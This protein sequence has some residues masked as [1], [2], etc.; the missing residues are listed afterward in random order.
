MV[1]EGGVVGAAA[2][3]E[4]RLHG[5]RVLDGESLV[6][7]ENVALVCLHSVEFAVKTVS[8]L[9]QII[10]EILDRPLDLMELLLQQAHSLRK[11]RIGARGI[12]FTSFQTLHLC[13]KHRAHCSY[14]L[15]QFGKS[16]FSALLELLELFGC[17]LLL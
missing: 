11:L 10:H 13:L 2:L 1:E 9:L 3:G 15:L 16:G 17:S 5:F 14:F 4:F 12:C 6:L 8:L 7:G